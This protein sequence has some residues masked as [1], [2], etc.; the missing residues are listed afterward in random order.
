MEVSYKGL[1]LDLWDND[2]NYHGPTPRVLVV[3]DKAINIE[4]YAEEHGFE[5]P[6][7]GE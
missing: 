3:G 2:G 6:D 1:I 4:E 5:L 7:S